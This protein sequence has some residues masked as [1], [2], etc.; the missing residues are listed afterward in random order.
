MGIPLNVEVR[1]NDG[2]CGRST[3]VVVNPV[4]RL[5][6]H[7]V[8]REAWFPHTEYMVPLDLVAESVPHGIRLH[9]TKSELKAQEPFID[10]EYIQGDLADFDY[11][12]SEFVMWPYSLPEEDVTMPLEIERV[13]PHELAVRR[14]AQVMATDGHVGH[15]D[16]FLVDPESGHISHLIMREGHL[17]GQRDVTIPVSAIARIEEDTVHLKLN[18]EQIEA[19][20]TIPVRR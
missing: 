10:V 15:V 12:R 13:P 19:L 3:Y 1:C 9:C 5:M 2:V 17:W 6:T 11:E 7:V 8:V 14:G 4:S 18:K 20:P 16:A